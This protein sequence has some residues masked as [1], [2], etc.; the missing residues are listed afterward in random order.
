MHLFLNNYFKPKEVLIQ[1]HGGINRLR[2]SELI[3]RVRDGV[4][5]AAVKPRL[6]YTETSIDEA[7]EWCFCSSMHRK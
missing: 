4:S 5:T 3:R 7:K 2:D 1:T 6:K